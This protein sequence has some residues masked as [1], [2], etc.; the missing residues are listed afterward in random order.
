MTATEALHKAA[1]YLATAAKSFVPHEE[2]DSHTNMGWN[3]VESTLFTRA[4]NDEGLRLELNHKAY[5][6]DVVHPKSGLSGSFPLI[7]AN[8]FAIVQWLDQERTFC[9][10]KTPY[11]F[12]LHYDLGYSNSLDDAFTFPSVPGDALE[13]EIQRRNTANDALNSILAEE[14]SNSSPRIWPHH[15]DTGALIE[16]GKEGI[17]SFGLGMAIPDAVIS[18]HYLYVSAYDS[19]GSISTDGMVE[20]SLGKWFNASWKGAAVPVNGLN[21]EM[22]IRFYREVLEAFRSRA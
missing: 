17:V 6:L 16:E 2:D 8:H 4:L 3:Q 5:A 9:G 20:L 12:D 21:T 18:E 1:Q 22:A 7:G 11:S 19:Q 14:Q 15:F 13:E 10:I